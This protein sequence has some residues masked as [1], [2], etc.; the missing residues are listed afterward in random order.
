MKK[1]F[2]IQ[3]S[4]KIAAT[5]A[6]AMFVNSG[7]SYTVV[8][9]YKSDDNSFEK[10]S[11]EVERY[12]KEADDDTKIPVWIWFEDIDQESL[13]RTVEETCGLSLDDISLSYDSF[14]NNF[15]LKNDRIL[16][17]KKK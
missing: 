1:G 10:I 4:K 12:I 15:L 7:I 6:V 11:S 13:V 3:V 14:S 8:N 16:F 9:A 5:I 17:Q 2:L